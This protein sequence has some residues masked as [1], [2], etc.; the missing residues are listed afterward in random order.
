MG[1]QPIRNIL[2][3]RRR[4]SGSDGRRRTIS[5]TRSRRRASCQMTLAPGG[6]VSATS[7][8]R[9]AATSHP[10]DGWRRRSS[11][12]S[13]MSLSVGFSGNTS[14]PGLPS[15]RPASNWSTSLTTARSG[16]SRSRLGLARRFRTMACRERHRR[17]ATE[18]RSS[19]HA[20]EVPVGLVIGGRRCE[21]LDLHGP[22]VPASWSSGRHGLAPVPQSW[23]SR[24]APRLCR[25]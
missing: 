17:S 19:R 7:G 1:G 18:A 21:V 22:T 12:T 24:P 4:T 9:G 13:P 5:R 25:T 15:R 3:Q 11:R 23:K 10:A 2:S 20:P 16:I 14:R 8:S 6:S